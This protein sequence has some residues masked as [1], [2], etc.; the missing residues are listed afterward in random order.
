M[1]ITLD[2]EKSPSG[3]NCPIGKIVATIDKCKD[4]SAVLGLTYVKEYNSFHL[5]AGCYWNN[6]EEAHF[7]AVVDPS[8]TSPASFGLKGGVCVKGK[9]LQC[10]RMENISFVKKH[11]QLMILGCYLSF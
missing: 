8:Q 7:N 9:F 4:A 10:Y 6:V 3:E 2:F 1:N 5:P 11:K